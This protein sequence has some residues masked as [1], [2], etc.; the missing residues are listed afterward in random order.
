MSDPITRKAEVK[1]NKAQTKA[2]AKEAKDAEKEFETT[3]AETAPKTVEFT[4]ITSL[5]QLKEICEQPQKLKLKIGD[6]HIEVIVRRIRSEEQSLISNMVAEVMPPAREGAPTGADFDPEKHLNYEDTTY[7]QK[8]TALQAKCR[9]LVCY[10]C[11]PVIHEG[12]PDIK[13]ADKIDEFVQSLLH[14]HVLDLIQ[15][16]AMNSGVTEATLANFTSAETS[17]ES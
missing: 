5:D 14:D 2:E 10:W 13:H 11:C 12:S 7:M 9:S 17:P 3:L 16:A 6:N 1:R 4:T 8:K 15:D